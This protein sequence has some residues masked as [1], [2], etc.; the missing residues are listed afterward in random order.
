[1]A[2]M[3][4]EL[5]DVVAERFRAL[6]EPMRIRILD[7][8]RQGELSVGELVTATHAT[9]ANVSKHLTVLHAI[10]FVA[11]RKE[12]TRAYYR[13]AE[14][15]V[16]KLCDLVCGGARERARRQHRALGAPGR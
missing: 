9:Q 16:F 15:D 12:G 1:M 13:V 3:T 5:T 11:R 2:R 14:P 7:A 10:G 6:G 4:P 8:L